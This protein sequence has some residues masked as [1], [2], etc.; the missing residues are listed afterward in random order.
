MSA[1]GFRINTPGS[2]VYFQMVVW[3]GN[4]TQG[5]ANINRMLRVPSDPDVVRVFAFDTTSTLPSASVT[6][7][8]HAEHEAHNHR[9]SSTWDARPVLTFCSAYSAPAPKASHFT[10]HCGLIHLLA[11][12]TFRLRAVSRGWFPVEVC[13]ICTLDPNLAG[14]DS[15]IQLGLQ[16]S[17]ELGIGLPLAANTYRRGSAMLYAIV[18]ARRCEN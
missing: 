6:R 10:G 5:D 8:E 16:I 7:I 2:T 13:A 17:F 12:R 18:F 11:I 4:A 9:N 15:A 1:L 3:V 14:K